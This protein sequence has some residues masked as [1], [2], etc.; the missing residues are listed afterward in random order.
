[1][2]TAVILVLFALVASAAA[3]PAPVALHAVFKRTCA[4][5]DVTTFCEFG[6]PGAPEDHVACVGATAA[7]ASLYKRYAVECNQGE[8]NCGTYCVLDLN[9]E[10][11]DCG[12]CGNQCTNGK[13]CV[14]GT[15]KC[16]EGEQ[17]CSGYCKDTSS[18]SSHCGTCG[19]VCATGYYCSN[20]G[21]VQE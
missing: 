18:D 6:Y 5:C 14:G 4:D 19:H 13:L 16:I 1:M 17:L 2:R 7:R 8:T 9:T 15:C 11:N 10:S 21:C 20:G 12:S 3:S